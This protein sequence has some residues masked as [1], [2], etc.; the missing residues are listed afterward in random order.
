MKKAFS[1]L[2]T[3]I[4]VL[5]V[6]SLFG[7]MVNQISTGKQKFGVLTKP[8]KSLYSFPNL[9]Q[10]TVKEVKKLPPTFLE[11]PSGF[12]TLNQLKKDL[13]VL[14]TYTKS[15]DKRTILLINLKNDS[16]LQEW[17][18]N[19]PWGETGRIVNPLIHPD[20]GSLIY[21]YYYWAKPGLTK[22]D[23]NGK[24]IWQNQKL[25]VHHGMNLNR[26]GDIWACTIRK[27]KSG[28]VYALGGERVFYNDYKITK[29]DH[30]TGEILF[31][32]SISK[33]F[34]E[35]GL[36]NYLFKSAQTHEP[37]HL[38]DVQPALKTTKYYQEDDVFISLRNINLIMHYRPK[39]NE[40]IDIIEGPFAHQHDVDFLNDSVIVLFNNNTY[41]TYEGM[42]IKHAKALKEKSQWVDLG[43]HFS[44]IVS[45]NL[46]TETFSFIGN[47]VFR[48]NRIYTVNEGLMEFLG[49]TSYFVEEQN[50][51]ILWVIENGE[52]IYKNVL[53][54]QHPGHHHLPNWTR[55]VSYGKQ[56]LY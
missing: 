35:N 6:L 28:G 49:P 19:N 15:D 52:V 46:E 48:E 36:V 22:L 5:T 21:N 40:L 23:T 18:V 53:P 12:K 43:S 17:T 32:K 7:W 38:N 4:I 54:S 27:G 1:Y 20:D 13:V 16:I 41:K 51:G 10:E 45:Y 56:R 39:S 34:K 9:F 29:Y 42:P 14:V 44:N 47:A 33:I 11:T 24:V 2:S 37:I 55:I 8:I 30:E 31:D 3:I 50:S 25:V 26:D